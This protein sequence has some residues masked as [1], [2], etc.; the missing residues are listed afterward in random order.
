MKAN[1]G[2][3]SEFYAFL[4]ILEDKK[5]F[6]ANKN[7]EIIAD[8]FFVFKKIIRNETNQE[9]KI[10]D[11][12]DSEIYILDSKGDVLKKIDD[13][14]I[15]G[16]TIKIFENIKK[17]KTTTFDIPE[18]E[19]LMN[20]L[21]C[22]QIKA[23]NSKKSDIDGIIY[24]RVSNKEELLGFSVKSMIGGAS[25]LLNAGKT[26]NFIYEITNFDTAKIDEINKIEGRSKIQDRLKNILDNGGKL[27]FDRISKE[28]FEI[29]LRKIDTVFPVF[30]AQMLQDF[31]L[32]KAN[33]ITDLVD[34]LEQNEDLKKMFRLSKS[35]YEYKIKNFLVSIALGMVPSKV[36]DG[37]TKAHGGYIVVKNNGDVICYHLYNRDEFLSYLYENTKFESASST[38][39]DYGKIYEENGKLYFNLN[40]QIR[41][42]K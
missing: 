4:K 5:L 23:D 18:A 12:K 19:E 39:H 9:T 38:R 11:L 7:L 33:K 20:I 14:K 35:D 29:N 34:L 3:W 24:D 30:I 36:W 27:S 41:F 1:K 22:T 2:E 31:F 16:K 40:L 28:E 42:L 17:A 37:F 26:T 32:G 21:L 13:T 15:K 8:K 10:F 6:A 25:T